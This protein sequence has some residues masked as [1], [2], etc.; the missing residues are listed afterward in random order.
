MM[1]AYVAMRG[2]VHG[3]KAEPLEPM[4][5]RAMESENDR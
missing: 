3:V 2:G 4:L 1:Q 5:S